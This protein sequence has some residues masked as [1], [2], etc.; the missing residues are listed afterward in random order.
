MKALGLSYITL[1][2][3]LNEAEQYLK[4]AQ[5]MLSEH[6]AMKS[7]KE[8]KM[9]LQELKEKKDNKTHLND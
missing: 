1:N 7:I 9:K 6:G 2:K 3:N 8:I 4:K 5:R